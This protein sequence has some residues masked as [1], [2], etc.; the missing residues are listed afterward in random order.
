MI[1]LAKLKQTNLTNIRLRQIILVKI[2]IFGVILL[3]Y[4]AQAQL[5]AGELDSTEGFAGLFSG[6]TE[7]INN[8]LI[9]LMIA[10][11]VLAFIYGVFVYFISGS[12]DEE[13]RTQG[14][15]LMLYAL[16]GFVAIV[17]LWGIVAFL[18]GAF[19]F[20]SGQ[21]DLKPPSGPPTGN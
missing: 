11:C 9:P 16:L 19:G 21:A 3:P 20:D 5:T 18:V 8:F 17:A 14:R 7:L 15:S 1:T 4:I 6:I 12:A 10:I 2:T 13:K